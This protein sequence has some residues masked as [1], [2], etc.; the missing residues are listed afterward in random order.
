MLVGAMATSAGHETGAGGLEPQPST[1]YWCKDRHTLTPNGLR[2]RRDTRTFVPAQP[3][4]GSMKA[5]SNRPPSR[6]CTSPQQAGGN[7]DSFLARHVC[8]RER[9]YSHCQPCRRFDGDFADGFGDE[10]MFPG[11]FFGGDGDDDGSD[12]EEM[13]WRLQKP[14]RA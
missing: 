14:S 6:G 8:D 5:P 7:A 1:Q 10:V 11:G 2:T 12:G 9:L 4:H 3:M 13:L